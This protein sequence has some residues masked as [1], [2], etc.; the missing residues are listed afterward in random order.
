M[1]KEIEEFDA[2]ARGLKL[3]YFK[4]A[5]LRTLGGSHYAEGKAK[6]LNA[7]PPKELW[8]NMAHTARMADEAR[9]RLKSPIVI[10]SGYR[11]KAYNGAVGGA[12][13][14]LHMQ[15]N[16]LDLQPAK[17]EVWRLHQII[18]QIRREGLFTGGIG[19]YNTF[20][21]VDTRGKNADF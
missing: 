10:V 5:E 4:P 8:N 17:E 3:R 2:W 19:K 6:G 21:H 15:F 20:V 13:G 14:S 1:S 18:S 9:H 12:S 7:L 11:N 16:A